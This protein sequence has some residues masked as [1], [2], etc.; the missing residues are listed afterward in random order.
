[1]SAFFLYAIAFSLLLTALVWGARL[2]VRREVRHISA[3][4]LTTAFVV[5]LMFVWWGLTRGATIEERVLGPLLLPS[6]REVLAAFPHLHFE[7]ALVRSA[8]R[9]FQRVGIGFSIAAIIAVPLGVY[10]ASYAGVAA[11]F[12]P[13]A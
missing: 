5:L 8:V 9:S 1:M 12:R 13:L 7:Q 4:L 10:M 6:P 11:F 2:R 3:I